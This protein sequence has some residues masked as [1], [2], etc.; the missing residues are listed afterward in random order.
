MLNMSHNKITNFEIGWS[1]NWLGLE[2]LDLSNNQFSGNLSLNALNFV[3][4]Y[5]LKFKV[6]LRNNFLEKIE[7][8]DRILRQNIEVTGGIKVNVENN[9]I[10]CDCD[11]FLFSSGQNRK[12]KSVQNISFVGINCSL[13]KSSACNYPDLNGSQNFYTYYVILAVVLPATAFMMIGFKRRQSKSDHI[14][15]DKELSQLMMHI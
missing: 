13:N 10:S 11:S 9:K 5:P 4:H 6:D 7:S 14:H 3:K 15:A 8:G 1:L 12:Y 2:I